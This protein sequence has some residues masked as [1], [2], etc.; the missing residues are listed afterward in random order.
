M[1]KLVAVEGIKVLAKHVGRPKAHWLLTYMEEALVA[2]PFTRGIEDIKVHFAELIEEVKEYFDSE[3]VALL[4]RQLSLDSRLQIAPRGVLATIYPD[5]WASPVLTVRI[6]K[7]A[8]YN[9]SIKLLC[10]H[11]SPVD[12]PL[13]LH[14]VT[15]WG[16][17]GQLVVRERGEFQIA[18]DCSGLTVTENL[19]VHIASESHFIPRAVDTRS[20]DERKLSFRVRALQLTGSSWDM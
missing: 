9:S 5:G 20:S 18:V 6:R 1:R 2:Y 13:K 14:I 3:T 8:P 7:L 17:E 16:M 11:V 4:Y 12:A 10:E 19:I 15:S